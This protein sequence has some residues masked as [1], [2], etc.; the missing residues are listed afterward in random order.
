MK[1][2]MVVLVI[3]AMMTVGCTPKPSEYDTPNGKLQNGNPIRLMSVNRLHPVVRTITLGFEDA[4]RDLG[5]VCENNS[6]EGVDFVAFVAS[7]DIALSQGTS[8]AIPFVDKAVIEADKK[9]IA[10]GV[11]CI[12]IH[13]AIPEGE[14]PGLLGWVAADATDYA[15]RS[16][17]AIGEKLGSKGVVAITQG[18]LNDLENVVTKVFTAKMNE[19]FP[20]ITVLPPEMEGFDQIA[21][22]AVATAILQKNQDITAAFGTTGNSPVTWAKAAEAVGK[23]P[24]DIVIVGMDYVRQN[25]DL[26][27]SGWV[28]ALVGQPL[29]EETYRAVELL[30]ANL[31][32][33]KVDYANPYPAPIIMLAD[34]GKYYVYAD[35][36]DASLEK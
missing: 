30:V 27:K 36:V 23:K 17:I 3:L 22:I 21:A 18:N 13:T 11:P 6:V 5:V 4:C 26:V 19:K 15:E 10:G 2:I 28:Y 34:L 32:G 35:R 29:Y 24:G 14:L 20:D 25:L 1:K 8:G 7:V 16:A 33:K 31:Q 12:N 9:L